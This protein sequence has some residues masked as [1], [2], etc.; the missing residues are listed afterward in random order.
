MKAGRKKTTP[1]PGETHG[2]CLLTEEIVHQLRLEYNP[3]IHKET[4]FNQKGSE[5]K[6]CGTTIRSICK[7]RTWKHI[8]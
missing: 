1:M 2:M 6:V 4:W 8:L 7:G 3:L 5:L